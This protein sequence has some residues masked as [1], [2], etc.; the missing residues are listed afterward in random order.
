MCQMQKLA[1]EKEYNKIV[2]EMQQPI[3]GYSK[4]KSLKPFVDEFVLEVEI[5]YRTYFSNPLSQ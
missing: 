2:V 3:E 5:E 1:K 4:E